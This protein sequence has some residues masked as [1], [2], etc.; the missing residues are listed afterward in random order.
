MDSQRSPYNSLLIIDHLPDETR[1]LRHWLESPS[2]QV[3]VAPENGRRGTLPDGLH[4]DL[5]LLNGDP[6]PPGVAGHKTPLRESIALCHQFQQNDPVGFLPVIMFVEDPEKLQDSNGLDIEIDDLLARPLNRQ[7]LLNSIKAML[8]HKRQYGA[9][10]E[11]NKHL[12]HEL[13]LHEADLKRASQGQQELSVLKDSIIS[14]VSHELRTP[15]LQIKSAVAMMADDVRAASPTGTSSLADHAVAATARLESVVQNITQLAT[16]MN[17]RRE[18]FR[19][20]DAVQIA[21][22]QLGRQWGSLN[23]VS[24]I[25]IKIPDIPVVTGDRNGVAQMLQQLLDNGIKFSPQGGSVEVSGQIEGQS[26]RVSVI[27]H[28]IGI[29]P[30]ELAH[31]FQAFYQ[32]DRSVTRRFGG[33]GVGLAIV[34]LL[35]DAMG[36]QI[37]VQSE[38]GVGSTFSFCVAIAS[39]EDIASLTPQ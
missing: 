9:L 22:R 24:R 27:D 2:I 4:P 13:A 14:T 29:P 16:S 19:L 32:V 5:I 39:A 3:Y 34:K 10:R 37:D 30:G 28:G 1:M 26:V 31:I 17:V 35:A 18:V 38:V 11:E 20:P 36:I 8:R 7:Q 15:L 23:N 25:K 12:A 21:V 6:P 33:T